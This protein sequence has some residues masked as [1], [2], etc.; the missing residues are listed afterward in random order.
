MALGSADGKSI[1][2][3]EELELKTAQWLLKEDAASDQ[4][5]NKAAH[6]YLGKLHYKLYKYQQ[7]L[8][9]EAE[10][11]KYLRLKRHLQKHEMRLSCP[12]R[13][14]DPF[15]CQF[16]FPADLDGELFMR[17]KNSLDAV[18]RVGCLTEHFDNRLMW[19]HYA[20]SHRGICIEYDFSSFSPSLDRVVFA[21]V[22]YSSKRPEF[23]REL[24]DHLSHNQL[25]L[26][27]RQYLTSALFTKDT[28]WKYESE[29]RILKGVHICKKYGAYLRCF[30]CHHLTQ[31]PGCYQESDPYFEFTM[32]PISAVYFGAAINDS[33][34]GQVAKKE[35][36]ELCSRA[37]IPTFSM[38]LDK[39]GYAVRPIPE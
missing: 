3:R 30:M 26:Q 32:P 22:V 38:R 5:F 36:Q 18:W 7:V 15:D 11:E 2:T 14:N 24:Q 23:T 20:D 34:K 17:C 31:M 37:G 13:F 21:P 19:S 12:S 4:A 8:S 6:A 16:A 10:K 1:I 39:A 9:S 25:N 29:W 28:I 35:L 27:D 33:C